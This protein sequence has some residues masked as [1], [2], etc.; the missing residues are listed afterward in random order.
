LEVNSGKERNTAYFV[1]GS[2]CC[3]TSL[4]SC[5]VLS[6]LLDTAYFVH[7]S[8]C[9][10][11]SLASCAVLSL[12]LDTTYFVRG[13]LAPKFTYNSLVSSNDSVPTWYLR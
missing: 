2:L 13:S 9:C 12:L 7:G 11:T 10:W 5:A 8:L 6:L 3:R 1:R 4:A